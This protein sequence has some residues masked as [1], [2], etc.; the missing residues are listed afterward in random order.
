MY[1]KDLRLSVLLDF[2]GELLTDKQRQAIEYYYDEDMSLSE[3]AEHL[4]ISRQGVRDSIKRGE[5]M[6]Y[7]M[8]AKLGL[9]ARFEQQ[10][11]NADEILRLTGE[12]SEINL[13]RSCIPDVSVRADKIT[14][15]AK[16]IL[17]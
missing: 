13:K 15:L 10:K 5:Q 6:L 16:E 11:K 1:E 9:A 3:I 7:N 2:Y 14:A 12:I 4:F 8:E 17:R